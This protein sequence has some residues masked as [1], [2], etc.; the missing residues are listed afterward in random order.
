M[1]HQYNLD[2]PKSIVRRMYLWIDRFIR[3]HKTVAI[4][5]LVALLLIIA[6]AV[7]S[8]YS[9]G[10]CQKQASIRI[11][12]ETGGRDPKTRY[13]Y[14]SPDRRVDSPFYNYVTK[15]SKHLFLKIDEIEKCKGDKI[16]DPQIELAFVYRPLISRQIQPFNFDLKKSNDTKYIDSPWL[17]LTMTKSP[18]L[19]VR[20]AFIW[21]ERQFLFDQAVLS[22][23]RASPTETLLPI[24]KSIYRRFSWDYSSKE[25]LRFPKSESEEVRAA[26]L[27]DLAKRIPADLMWLFIHSRWWHSGG[28]LGEMG[29]DRAIEQQ[30]DRYIDLTKALLNRRFESIQ[31]EQHY[32]SILNLKQL[33]DLDRYR[34]GRIRYY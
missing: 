24:D 25:D 5:F 19:V 22:G 16:S 29:M 15:I 27:T 12:D 9:V 11:I 6:F 33:F 13:I 2:P 26:I 21:N 7:K 3:S 4:A 18:K 30:V 23:A 1:R 32:S 34:I 31:I 17:K 20:A 10:S 28:L 8:S 14:P